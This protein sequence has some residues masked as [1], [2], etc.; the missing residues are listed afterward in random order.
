MGKAR[1]RKWTGAT[2]GQKRK[3][4]ALNENPDWQIECPAKPER[5][6]AKG[7]DIFRGHDNPG[8]DDL[9]ITYTI[10]SGSRWQDLGAF[11]NFKCESNCHSVLADSAD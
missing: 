8:V 2:A 7:S 3:A 9:D 4:D 10:R 5:V 6:Q 11:T 1:T